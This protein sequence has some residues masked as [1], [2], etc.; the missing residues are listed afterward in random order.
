MAQPPLRHTWKVLNGSRTASILP[1][2]SRTWQ[3][4]SLTYGVCIVLWACMQKKVLKVFVFCLSAVLL[5]EGL[6]CL[7]CTIVSIRMIASMTCSPCLCNCLCGRMLTTSLCAMRRKRKRRMRIS[8]PKWLGSTIPKHHWWRLNAKKRTCV[9][10]SADYV[11][12]HDIVVRQVWLGVWSSFV[13][14][15]AARSVPLPLYSRMVYVCACV[16]VHLGAR[17]C[18]SRCGCM[19]RC[20]QWFART[21]TINPGPSQGHIWQGEGVPHVYHAI[22]CRAQVRV[23]EIGGTVVCA[24]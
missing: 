22:D 16:C 9:H 19:L 18:P 13:F 10:A 8:R 15:C 1:L 7:A 11:T 17:F 20:S 2:H 23:S 6:L 3:A 21:E 5:F 12:V 4:L 14:V 24:R